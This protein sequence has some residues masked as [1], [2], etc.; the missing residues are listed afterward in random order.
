MKK[1]LVNNR[2]FWV[3]AITSILLIVVSFLI[4]PTGVVDASVL[5]AVGELFGFAS[6]G[7]VIK[8]I[9]KGVDARLSKGDISVE[10]SNDREVE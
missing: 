10:I 8:S 7:T 2:W 5:A 9:D 6:L 3:F 4:P 1:H